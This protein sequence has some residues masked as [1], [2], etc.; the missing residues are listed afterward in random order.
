MSSGAEN[1]DEPGGRERPPSGYELMC[2][3]TVSEGLRSP[4]QRT[5][6]RMPAGDHVRRPPSGAHSGIVRPE[7]AWVCLSAAGAA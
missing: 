5:E 1:A 7:P 3:A 6:L 4:E 2:P